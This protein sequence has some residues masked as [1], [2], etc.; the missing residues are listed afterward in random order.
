MDICFTPGRNPTDFF[1]GGVPS[2]V[3]SQPISAMA[4]GME[5]SPGDPEHFGMAR[6]RKPAGLC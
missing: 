5:R 6:G 2:L 3:P 1:I 4:E